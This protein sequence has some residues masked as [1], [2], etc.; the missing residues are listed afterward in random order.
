MNKKEL[1]EKYK[2][3]RKRITDKEEKSLIISNTLFKLEEFCKA[4][5]VGIYSS[6]SEEVDTKCIIEYCLKY[7][8][9][10]AF[11]KVENSEMRFYY[12]NNINDLN[13]VGSFGIMEPE[14][15][16]LAEDIEIMIVP[17]ICFDRQNNRIGFGGGYYDKYLSKNRDIFKIGICFREQITEKIETNETDIKMDII[18]TD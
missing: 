7:N 2:K 4:N 3:I 11:P 13:R 18:I 16:N 17:G 9:K 15:N 1:R 12:I 5:V 10:I 14:G 6:L 8:K